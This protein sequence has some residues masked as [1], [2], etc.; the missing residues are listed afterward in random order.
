VY[1]DEWSHELQ[2]PVT[3]V[4]LNGLIGK[5][6]E[7]REALKPFATFPD[8]PKA[9]DNEI[10]SGFAWIGDESFEQ[11]ESL[12]TEEEASLTVGH[13]RKARTAY[14]SSPSK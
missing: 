2:S 1:S 13:L 5:L 6:K 8:R 11:D 7:L 3:A 4:E 14:K 9:P 12:Y 10:T